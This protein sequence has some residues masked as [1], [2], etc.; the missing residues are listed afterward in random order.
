MI[1][2]RALDSFASSQTIVHKK[3]SYKDAGAY[4]QEEKLNTAAYMAGRSIEI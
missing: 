4:M 1:F 3:L 2:V